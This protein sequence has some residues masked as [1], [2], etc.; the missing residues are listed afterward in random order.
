ME[1]YKQYV[2]YIIA[3]GVAETAYILAL[4]NGQ[5]CG[6]N[7]PIKQ[8]PKYEFELEDDKDPSKT[9]KVVVDER[10]N[11]LD[12]IAHDGV[13]KQPTGIRLY[14]QK[15]YLSHFDLK[16]PKNKAGPKIIYLKKVTIN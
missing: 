4:A 12:A 15:Y 2:D 8:M 5:I 16:D 6:T 9:H 10:V 14:N 13:C 7:L 11:L 3:G 1:A